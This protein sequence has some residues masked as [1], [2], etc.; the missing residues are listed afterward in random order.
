MIVLRSSFR[1]AMVKQRCSRFVYVR[2]VVFRLRKI[3]SFN[4][5]IQIVP[6]IRRYWA[7]LSE[8]VDSN[9]FARGISA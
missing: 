4:L 6:A 1:G 9:A 8:S 5:F 3:L 2:A 7:L